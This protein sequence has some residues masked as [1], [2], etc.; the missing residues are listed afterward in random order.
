MS[1]DNALLL[2]SDLKTLKLPT[3][4][5]EYPVIAR[6]CAEAGVDYEAFLQQ[7]AALEVQHRQSQATQRRLKQAGFPVIKEL[8]QFDFAATPK[9][10]KPL[11]LELARGTFIDQR[12]NAVF[13]GPPGVGKTHLGIALGR[14]A[15]RRGYK[16]K[17]FT[18]A[19][20]ANAYI[21]AR[22]EKQVTRLENHIRRCDLI[23][24]DELGYIPLERSGAEH[25]F[26]FF[27]QCYETTSL[28]VTTNVPFADW[29]Q[30]FAGDER[31]AGAL[32]D[33]L[34]HHVQVVEME[35][36]SY[37]FQASMKRKKQRKG[38]DD[39]GQA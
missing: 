12:H 33:R 20:L 25:L 38:G 35:G 19:A 30:V 29:P 5:K 17:F 2:K 21:E 15:C 10:N 39:P 14:E 22:E 8:D 13:V 4:L 37:R 9:V 27:S 36:D 31:L 32:L 24:V 16:V 18:A 11:I 7:L 26:S 23:V 3:F 34:T 6:Q 28:I 1:E